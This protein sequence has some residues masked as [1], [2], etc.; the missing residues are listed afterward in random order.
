M[1]YT[2]TLILGLSLSFFATACKSGPS[3]N[4]S[5]ETKTS[6]LVLGRDDRQES[7]RGNVNPILANKVGLIKAA[8]T[9]VQGNTHGISCTGTLIAKNF[10]LTA[11]HCLFSTQAGNPLIRN[12][13]F[14]PAVKTQ[15]H[16]PYGRFKI[17]RSFTVSA[18]ANGPK[19]AN[20]DIDFAVMELEP[21]KDGKH[22]GEVVGYTSYWGRE[23]FSS[24][25]VLTL[26]YPGDLKKD[27]QY[28]ENDCEA[29][30][31]YGNELSLTCDVFRGQ[32][33]GPI[34]MYSPEHKTYYAMGVI[35][36]HGS[37][38]NGGSFL[39]KE[40]HDILN[41]IISGNFNPENFEEKWVQLNHEHDNVINLFVKN[42]CNKP[43]YAAVNYKN[44]SGKWVAEGL[45]QIGSGKSAQLATTDNGVFYFAATLDR[46]RSFINRE[47]ITRDLTNGRGDNL[48][49]EKHSIQSYN[50]YVREFG[51]Y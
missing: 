27:T 25:K 17:K 43:I 47:D 30:L 18:Y 31:S 16:M 51:C 32:S 6:A 46:G 20:D 8:Y 9:D 50:D 5:H 22:A 28:F 36:S 29:K 26:G 44:S 37:I 19:K 41:S 10:I 39:S 11:S 12:A 49:F 40:R 45:Y 3:N 38:Q 23:D 14:I 13:F 1:S 35:T 4:D 33:G 7:Q 24:G 2:N 34:I 48:P 42:R 21:N 15:G